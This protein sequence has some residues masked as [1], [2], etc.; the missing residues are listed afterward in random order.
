MDLTALTMVQVHLNVPVSKHAHHQEPGTAETKWDAAITY[1]INYTCVSA[2]MTYENAVKRDYCFSTRCML[3]SFSC[4]GGELKLQ[5]I[6]QAT[7]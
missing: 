7:I 2:A 1:V 3:I 4:D 5:D 6:F